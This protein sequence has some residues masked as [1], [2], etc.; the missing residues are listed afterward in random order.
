MIRLL[1]PTGGFVSEE[2][3]GQSREGDY[4][5]D[6]AAKHNSIFRLLVTL[7]LCCSSSAAE[8]KGGIRQEGGRHLEAFSSDS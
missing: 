4:G 8:D 3:Q 6:G 2:N 5:D 7:V 1:L